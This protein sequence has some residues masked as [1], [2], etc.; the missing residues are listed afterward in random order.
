MESNPMSVQQPFGIVVDPFSIWNIFDVTKSDRNEIQARIQVTQ[1][2][3]FIDASQ[4]DDAFSIRLGIN[5]VNIGIGWT[6]NLP[7]PCLGFEDGKT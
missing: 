1:E 2:L 6:T 4:H 5:A 7:M 3:C